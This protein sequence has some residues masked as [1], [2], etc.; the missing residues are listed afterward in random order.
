MHT[1]P[2]L[3]GKP[4]PHC[5]RLVETVRGRLIGGPREPIPAIRTTMVLH[6]YDIYSHPLTTGRTGRRRR[7]AP[8]PGD[9]DAEFTFSDAPVRRVAAPSEHPASDRDRTT[10]RATVATTTPARCAAKVEA[11]VETSRVGPKVRSLTPSKQ[12]KPWRDLYRPTYRYVIVIIR[13]PN[14]PPPRT[15]S[16]SRCCKTYH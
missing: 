7:S 2:P 12:L 15:S 8:S 5:G 3:C 4:S 11:T 10:T 9:E 16:C 1:T 6:G 13:F 14:P